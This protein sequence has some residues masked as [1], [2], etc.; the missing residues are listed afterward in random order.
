MQ[1]G[2]KP[3]NALDTGREGQP[4]APAGGALAAVRLVLPVRTF[5]QIALEY[6][7]VRRGA[8]C[9]ARYDL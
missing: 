8:P 3:L 9:H 7:R 2:R 1:Q 6:R 5:A 4:G